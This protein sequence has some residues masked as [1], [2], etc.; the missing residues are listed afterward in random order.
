MSLSRSTDLIVAVVF[1]I[2]LAP[3]TVLVALL[4]RVTSPGPILV[5]Q[6][7]RRDDG[8]VFSFV[9]FR[10]SEVDSNQPTRIGQFLR[11][12]GLHLLPAQVNFLR[13]EMN[14]RDFC[15]LISKPAP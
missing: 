14:R 12:Y 11:K 13:G 8:T 5:R 6:P 1:L 7:R 4:V 10:T 15:D 2:L 3:T 9:Q